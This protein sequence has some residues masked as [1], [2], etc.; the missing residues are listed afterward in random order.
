MGRS[1]APRTSLTTPPAN[2]GR[3]PRHRIQEARDPK[4]LAQEY[5]TWLKQEDTIGAERRLARGLPLTSTIILEEASSD[6][7]DTVLWS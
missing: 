1:S 7:D 3:T 6:S 5:K 4:A 2:Q